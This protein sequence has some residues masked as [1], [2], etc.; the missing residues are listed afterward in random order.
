MNIIADLPYEILNLIVIEVKKRT[1]FPFTLLFVSKKFNKI[2]KSNNIKISTNIAEYKHV[3]DHTMIS[4]SYNAALYNLPNIALWAITNKLGP[5]QFEN[6]IPL[7]IAYRN[8]N[9]LYDIIGAEVYLMSF[10]LNLILAQN[11]YYMYENL[12]KHRLIYPCYVDRIC[13]FANIHSNTK[14]LDHIV[15]YITY[16]YRII[17]ANYKNKTI[18]EWLIQNA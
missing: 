15:G 1:L 18:D 5:T 11:N 8:E 6:L 7:L 10:T 17:L 2:S 3:V 4:I 14:Y 12:S 16:H 9:E 13:S